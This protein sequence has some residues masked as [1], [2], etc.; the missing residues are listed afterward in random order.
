MIIPAK[1][2]E[3]RS[4]KGALFLRFLLR[5][6]YYDRFIEY[7]KVSIEECHSV[8]KDNIINQF[9]VNGQLE[10]DIFGELMNFH[11][12]SDNRYL[13]K[14]Y[15]LWMEIYYNYQQGGGIKAGLST[16]NKL[17]NTFS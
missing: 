5:F 6:G 8:K 17:K 10:D 2:Q 9:L 7:V 1:T 12:F 14:M 16:L 13:Q 4:E 11:F 3:T 15:N